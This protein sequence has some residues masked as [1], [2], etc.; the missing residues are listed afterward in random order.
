MGT[1][2]ATPSPPARNCLKYNRYLLF[3]E[4]VPATLLASPLPAALEFFLV[5]SDL[6]IMNNLYETTVWG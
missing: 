4:L 1:S 5:E 6:F 3:Y 2:P